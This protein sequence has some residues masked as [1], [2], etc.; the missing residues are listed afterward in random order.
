[1]A[2]SLSK[3]AYICDRLKALEEVMPNVGLGRL[4]DKVVYTAPEL[5][6]NLWLQVYDVLLAHPV[7]PEAQEIWNAACREYN[8]Y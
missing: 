6:D 1:M 7:V 4:H 5:L 3:G 2:T 8:V